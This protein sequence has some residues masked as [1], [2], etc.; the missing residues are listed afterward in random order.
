MPY[1]SQIH[2]RRLLRL[3]SWDY[4]SPWWYYVTIVVKDHQCAFGLANGDQVVLSD[5]G[6]AADRCWKQIPEHH[7]GVELG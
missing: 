1:D 3:K 4:S 6:T 2:H 7:G 5:I